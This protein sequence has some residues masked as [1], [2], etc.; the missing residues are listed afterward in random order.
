MNTDISVK[1]EIRI[2]IVA[3]PTHRSQISY[4]MT[5]VMNWISESSNDILHITPVIIPH[6]IDDIV[7]TDTLRSIHGIIIPGSISSNTATINPS[8]ISNSELLQMIRT[9]WDYTIAEKLPI[10]TICLGTLLLYRIL[11]PDCDYDNTTETISWD[12]IAGHSIRQHRHIWSIP[13]DITANSDIHIY[14]TYTI[15]ST[16]YMSSAEMK[17]YPVK[18]LMWHPEMS[19]D[20][21][22]RLQFVSQCIQYRDYRKNLPNESRNSVSDNIATCMVTEMGSWKTKTYNSKRNQEEWIHYTLYTYPIENI[23]ELYQSILATKRPIRGQYGT[24]SEYP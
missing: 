13:V 7:L 17:E 12:D 14:D 20:S 24:S 9:I 23:N 8:D 21:N 10:L 2:G 1:K 15:D 3:Y 11:Y 19:S 16:T 4:V 5:R 22:E 18:M 6:N